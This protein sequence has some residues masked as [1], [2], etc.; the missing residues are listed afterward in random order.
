V[1]VGN[2]SQTEP[3]ISEGVQAAN[4]QWLAVPFLIVFD[5]ADDPSIL[6]SYWPNSGP[7]S[8]IVT[9]NNPTKREEGFAQ[10]G[11]HIR[12]FSDDIGAKFLLSLLDE[13]N[14]LGAEDIQAAH[15]LAQ[16]YGGLPLALR[17]AASFMRSKRCSPT[18]F[19]AIYKSRFAEIEAFR[20]PNYQKTMVDV[21]SMS[22]S[23]LS[24]DSL[25]LLDVL[26][27]L[28]PDS[29]PSE[30]FHS[31]EVKHVDGSFMRDTLGMLN[32][33]ERLANQS[34][35]E[36]N[37]RE[38]SLNVHRFFQ[39]ATFRKL[40][41][42]KER[43]GSV[44]NLAT[45]LVHHFVPKNDLSAVRHPQSW[46]RIQRALSHVFS[47]YHRCV[48]NISEHEAGRLL[49]CLAQLV[50]YAVRRARAARNFRSNISPF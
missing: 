19:L 12:E 7:G 27:L 30:L 33:I 41:E 50:K 48:N 13:P 4:E 38:K 24:S 15:A 42:S 31:P 17:Q 37:Q 21:W 46:K 34:L 47:L 35:V 9:S 36:F 28:D 23:T 20:V 10:H 11:L 1:S 26:A 25:V 43:F 16:L 40:S 45:E 3:F 2:S 14:D 49:A 8:I 22:I 29:V 18:Q 6:S 5:N 44:I 39:T 32:A